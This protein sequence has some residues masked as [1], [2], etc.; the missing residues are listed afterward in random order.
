M[1]YIYTEWFLP[2][3]DSDGRHTS[4]A[5]ATLLKSTGYSLPSFSQL[6]IKLEAVVQWFK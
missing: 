5:K 3:K 2:Y 6:T 1:D 4:K